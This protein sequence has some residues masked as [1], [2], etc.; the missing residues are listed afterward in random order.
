MANDAPRA[1]S[2]VRRSVSE[3]R[4]CVIVFFSRVE[5]GND[6][7]AC[8]ECAVPLAVGDHDAMA[9]MNVCLRASVRATEY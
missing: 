1:S 6:R 3:L 4:G 5:S 9:R 2:D 7:E 8:D